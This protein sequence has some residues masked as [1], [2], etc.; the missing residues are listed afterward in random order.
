VAPQSPRLVSLR[1]LDVAALVAK[2]RNVEANRS[3]IG[4]VVAVALLTV[5]VLGGV[6][7]LVALGVVAW[8]LIPNNALAAVAIVVMVPVVLWGFTQDE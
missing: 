2:L 5:C 1:D 3:R 8:R 4:R 6:G 7:G